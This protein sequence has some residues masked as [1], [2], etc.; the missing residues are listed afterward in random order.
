MDSRTRTVGLVLALAGLL[1]VVDTTVTVAALPAIV[2]DLDTTLPRGSWMTTGYILGLIAVIP[3]SG[4]LAGRYGDR[5]VYLAGLG[6]FVVASVAAGFSPDVGWLI[7]FRVLQGLGGGVLNPLGQ[8]IA[9]RSA[10]R[11]HRG[12]VMSLVGLPVLIGPVLG[13]PLSALLVDTASWRWLFW[14]NLPFGAVALVLCLRYLPDAQRSD[15]EGRV[16][17]IGLLL[18][19]TGCVS[20]VLAGT[21]IGDSGRLTVGTAATAVA[22]LVMLG[23]FARR[24]LGRRNPLVH[25]GLLARREVVSGAVISL[26]FAGGYFGSMAIV[27][28]FVQGVRGDPVSVAGVL[29]I[30]TGLAVGI[31]LQVATR[32]V[33]RIDPRRVIMTGTATALCGALGLGLALSLNAPYPFIGVVSMLVGIGS[34]ATLMPTTV[35]ATRTLDGGELPRATTLLNLFSQLGNALGTALVAS[36]ITVL[37]G[38]RADDIGAGDRGGLAAMVALDP[39]ERAQLAGELSA[40]VGLSYIT[41]AILIMAAL[42]TAVLGMRARL[43]APSPQSGST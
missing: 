43:S 24:S 22:G 25:V 1:I 29:A 3:L 31:T 30:P 42:A 32:L 36:T 5:N 16:D 33:D 17:V 40:G 12:K 14:I 28:A 19:V 18:V 10:P 35:A 23:G 6:V 13:T 34:G 38:R 37:V 8:A 2:A 26:C 4:W 15:D 41:P 7:A 20:L 9:L 27:P 11:K 39:G 21:S